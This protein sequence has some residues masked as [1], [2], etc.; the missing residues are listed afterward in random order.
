MCACQYVRVCVCEREILCACVTCTH[1]CICMPMCANVFTAVCMKALCFVS[2]AW[3]RASASLLSDCTAVHPICLPGDGALCQGRPSTLRPVSTCDKG[4]CWALFNV[5]AL[6][7]HA[8]IAPMWSHKQQNMPPY[9]A[10]KAGDVSEKRE[11]L[12]RREGIMYLDTLEL[13]IV[14]N[15]TLMCVFCC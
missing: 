10:D 2:S 11:D 1:A 7:V 13:K 8:Q 12:Q 6:C 4:H 14:G 9:S 15:V 3:V 5:A